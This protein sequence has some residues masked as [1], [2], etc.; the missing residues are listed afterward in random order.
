MG[1]LQNLLL[2]CRNILTWLISIEIYCIGFFHIGVETL[3]KPAAGEPVNVQIVVSAPFASA[4]SDANAPSSSSVTSDASQPI[5]SASDFTSN[6]TNNN[7]LSRRRGIFPLPSLESPATI[8]FQIPGKLPFNPLDIFNVRT[9]KSFVQ[10]VTDRFM[11]RSSGDVGG[12][13]T[14][15]GDAVTI[16][17]G[18]DEGRSSPQKSP[19]FRTL[20]NDK[21]DPGGLEDFRQPR[22]ENLRGFPAATTMSF[23]EM[24]MA[25][26]S[27]IDRQVAT[28]NEVLTNEMSHDKT[29]TSTSPSPLRIS[30]LPD[31]SALGQLFNWG[32]Q[33][34]RSL[35]VCNACKVAFGLFVSQVSMIRNVHTLIIV[36]I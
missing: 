22:S 18:E 36:N 27:M 19:T 23:D 21:H 20:H 25:E 10:S 8:N 26:E 29:K 3:Q 13:K 17:S 7:G 16:I 1:Y 12:Y 14:G 11:S 32:E 24:K 35:A 34:A 4:P 5:S 31:L 33:S 6:E 15:F 30:F 9:F 28:L 2:Y